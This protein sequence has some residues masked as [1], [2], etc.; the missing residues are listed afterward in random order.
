MDGRPIGGARFVTGPDWAGR[1]VCVAAGGFSI[2]RAK[3]PSL[4]FWWTKLRRAEVEETEGRRR[5]GVRWWDCGDG[6]GRRPLG[7]LRACARLRPRRLHL[8]GTRARPRPQGALPLAA[9]PRV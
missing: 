7:R 1:S 5:E 4:P 3:A 9:A 8:Q 6:Q 2:D